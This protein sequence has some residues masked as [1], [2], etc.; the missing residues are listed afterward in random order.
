MADPTASRVLVINAGSS[1]L[2]FQLLAPGD[3]A[4]DATGIV[5]RVGQEAGT[6]KIAAG[7]RTSTFEGPVADH[8]EAMQIVES[9][10]EDVG[11]SLDDD[12]IRAVGHRVV[13]GGARYSAPVLIDD[14]VRWD[15]HDLGKLAPLHNYAAVDGI[16]GAKA[17]LPEVPHVAVFDTAFFTA[18]PEA[19]ATY[20]LNREVAQRYRV[21]RYGA[22]GTS[23]QFVSETVSEHLAAQGRDVSALRQIVLHLGNGASASAVRGGAAVETSMGLTPLEGLVMGT[24]TGDI[25]PSVYIHLHRQAGYS[26]EDVDTVL[27]KRSGMIG[28]CGMSDFRDITA[29]VEAGDETATLAMDVYV[30]RLKKYL[31]SYSFVLGGLD[32]IAFTAGIG[33]N[34]P[35]VRER[36]LAGLEGFG[37]ELD[38]AANAARS[39]ELRVIST[40]ESAVTVMVVPTDEELSIARQSAAVAG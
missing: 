33:E 29:A 27:N 20:A 7:E 10:F 38:R 31:G 6:A 37:I 30:H 22:H 4:V 35:M 13:Q 40:P 2:K 3:G 14:Q 1:S 18:L 9:L 36:L 12:R 28:M 17:L 11:L 23:H 34:V 25:D 21:R 5:E 39:S 19:A 26:A 16:D 8:K 15:I 24:R 32:V